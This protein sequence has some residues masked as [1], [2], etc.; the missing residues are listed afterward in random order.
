MA[1]M[2]D[3][4][5]CPICGKKNINNTDHECSK[6]VLCAIEGANTRMMRDDN[7]CYFSYSKYSMVEDDYSEESSS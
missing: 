7:I 4:N 5:W 3:F 6:R 1:D 2:S